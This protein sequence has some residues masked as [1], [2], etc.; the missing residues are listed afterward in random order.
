VESKDLRKLVEI[1]EHE[2]KRAQER[3][4]GNPMEYYILARNYMEL[5]Y[6][7]LPYDFV[8]GEELD[9]KTVNESIDRCWSVELLKDT[10]SAA[11][12]G[13]VE[14][15]KKT[16]E[17]Q[18][19]KPVRMAMEYIDNNYQNKISLEETA[20]SIGINASYLSA[21]FKKETGINFQNYLT[22]VRMEKA[23]ELLK[24]TN[25]TMMSIA[26]QVGYQDTRYFSETFYKVVGVKPSIYR[27]MYS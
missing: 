4:A 2:L 23:K 22:Q 20:D 10:V 14:N 25:E 16:N 26:I 24:M 21:L 9:K 5:V 8:P 13:I 1:F 12:A 3:K 17:E 19:R 7:S 15:L 27:K 11:V 18:S 6:D